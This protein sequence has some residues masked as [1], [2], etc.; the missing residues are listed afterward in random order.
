MPGNGPDHDPIPIKV[1]TVDYTTGTID[2]LTV[3][4]TA[5]T[6]SLQMKYNE[7]EKSLADIKKQYQSQTKTLSENLLTRAQNVTG[8]FELVENN[9]NLI[10][11]AV[12]FYCFFNK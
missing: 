5:E 10:L 1:V 6:D 4:H 8:A 12:V 3:L 9:L 2:P 7:N 11:I